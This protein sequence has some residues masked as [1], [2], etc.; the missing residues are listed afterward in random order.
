MAKRKSSGV[1]MPAAGKEPAKRDAK[2]EPVKKTEAVYHLK[3]TLRDVQPPVWRRVQV[4]DCTLSELHKVIQVAMGWEFSHLYSF[5]CNYELR[6]SFRW[7][8]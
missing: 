5:G 1:G 2:S 4:Q 7:R 3:I 6:L 8:R